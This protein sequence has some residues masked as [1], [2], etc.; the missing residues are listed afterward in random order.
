MKPPLLIPRQLASTS[1]DA[2]FSYELMHPGNA[3]TVLAP[4]LSRAD[5]ALAPATPHLTSGETHLALKAHG[6][7][8]EKL[9]QTTFAGEINS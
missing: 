6:T 5:L 9:A 7:C 3:A 4:E 1:N 2:T 8:A